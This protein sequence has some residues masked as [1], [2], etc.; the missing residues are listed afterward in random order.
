MLDGDA[1]PDACVPLGRTGP[2]DQL[3]Y[4]VIDDACL[5]GRMYEVWQGLPE[6][7]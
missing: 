2:R 7:Y 3:D 1:A 4:R 5:I 6:L